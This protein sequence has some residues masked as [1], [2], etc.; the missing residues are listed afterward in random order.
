MSPL[1]DLMA[2]VLGSDILGDPRLFVLRSQGC[3]YLNGE[4]VMRLYETVREE[5]KEDRECGRKL[6]CTCMFLELLK[7]RLAPPF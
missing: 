4:E 3:S 1:A 2:T 5:V 6:L 7:C